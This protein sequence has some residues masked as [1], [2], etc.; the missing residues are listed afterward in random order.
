MEEFVAGVTERIVPHLGA[1]PAR[2][3][4]TRRS[5]AGGVTRGDRIA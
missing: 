4:R 3:G 5:P 1:D 2:G